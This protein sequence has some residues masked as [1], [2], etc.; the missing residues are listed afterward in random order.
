MGEYDAF[1]SWVNDN[2]LYQPD[3]A[4]NTNVAMAYLLGAER[5]FNKQPTIEIGELKMAT[6][7][8]SRAVSPAMTVTVVVKDGEKVVKCAA[9]KVKGM[10]EVTRNMG[11]WDG[12][13]KLESTVVM[14]MSGDDSSKMRFTVFP[15]DSAASRAFLRVKVK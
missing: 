12:A 14:E 2:N 15:G 3:V 6:S 7:G 5:L 1:R 13:A 9:E 8:T 10:F 4:A 11:D